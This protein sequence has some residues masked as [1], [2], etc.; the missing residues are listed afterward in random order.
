MFP[1]LS[2]TVENAKDNIKEWQKLVDQKRKKGWTPPKTKK[3]DDENKNK[4][5]GN[6]KKKKETIFVDIK[7]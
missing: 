2:F 6:I 4:K 5:D 3:N 1:S 7:I